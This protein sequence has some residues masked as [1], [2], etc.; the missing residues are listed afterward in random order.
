MEELSKSESS[1]NEGLYPT[2]FGYIVF[3]HNIDPLT[4]N[5]LV[6]EI[7][8]SLNFDEY[9][10]N[11]KLF[12]K[13]VIPILSIL[14]FSDEYG[15]YYTLTDEQYKRT[16]E[17][18]NKYGKYLK[19]GLSGNNDDKIKKLI[20]KL[21]NV[22]KDIGLNILLEVSASSDFECIVQNG[23]NQFLDEVIP[24]VYFS[25]SA[26]KY[27]GKYQINDIYLNRLQ[28]LRNKYKEYLENR[29]SG[30]KQKEILKIQG[31]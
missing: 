11:F 12:L 5:A 8:N 21:H 20:G 1:K 13:D 23:Y 26:K 2:F 4:A 27:L 7:E 31:Y 22:N 16:I 25:D 6:I 19:H 29:F 10:G 14:D 15:N 18:N 30:E 9:I 3:L 28:Y 24:F 17:L